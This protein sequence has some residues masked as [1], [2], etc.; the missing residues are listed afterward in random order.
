MRVRRI[1]L[2]GE[3]LTGRVLVNLPQGNGKSKKANGFS[4][5]FCRIMERGL[6]RTDEN[7]GLKPI[8]GGSRQLAVPRI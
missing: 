4:S 7:P 1:S 5:Q 2:R 6:P 8:G 3:S